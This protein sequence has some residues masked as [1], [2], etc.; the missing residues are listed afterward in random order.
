M[1]PFDDVIIGPPNAIDIDTAMRNVIIYVYS[2]IIIWIEIYISL[3]INCIWK[4]RPDDGGH[5]VSAS[6]F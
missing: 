6:M 5:F 4:C 3:F 2:T 1:L